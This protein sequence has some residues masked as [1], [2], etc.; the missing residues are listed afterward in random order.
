MSDRKRLSAAARLWERSWLRKMKLEDV[1]W[2]P[3]CCC[4]ICRQSGREE[5][6]PP[7][8]MELVPSSGVVVRWSV[9]IVEPWWAS[10]WA[11]G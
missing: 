4:P 1:Q 6:A 7:E 9:P 2:N 10:F 3:R 8:E 11:E 5:E